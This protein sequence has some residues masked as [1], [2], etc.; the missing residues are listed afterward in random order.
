M[1]TEPYS[2]YTD[3]RPFRIAFLVNPELGAEWIDRII[4]Y[5]RDKWGGRFNPII[6]T[7]GAT[8][9][10][11]WWKFLREYDPDI[12]CSTVPLS[13][14]SRKKIHIF[15]SPLRL[16]ELNPQYNYIRIDDLPVSIFPTRKNISQI[17]F[18]D[19]DKEKE[20]IF[21]E[22]DETTPEVIKTFLNRNFGLFGDERM[23]P[24]HLKKALE[25]C[26]IKKYKV[27]DEIS[28]NEALLD[29]G[30][31][32]TRAV[33]LAQICSL[34]NS[35]KES[36][37]S[38]NNEKFEIIIGDTTDEL[39][40][41]WNRT[42]QMGAWLRTGFTQLWVPRSFAESEVLRP[43]LGK[44]V[45]KYVGTTG[46]DNGRGAHYV[47][48]SLLDSELQALATAI[49][50]GSWHP[51]QATK[52]I[53]H[54]F[55]DYESRG[56]RF[57]LKQ[58][59]DF[60]R[61]HSNEEYLVLNEPSVEEGVMG[62]EHWFTDLYI[63]YRPERFKNIIGRDY[64]W[65]LPRR[66]SILRDLHMFNR[67]A[68]IN[69]RGMFSILMRR[70]TSFSPEDNKVIVKIP[71]DRSVFQTL[72]CGERFDC[73]DREEGDRF[74]SR[75]FYHTQRSDKGM[76][77]SGVLGLFPDL[78]NAQSLFEERYWRET[79]ERMS[80][81]NPEKDKTIQQEL[82]NK[83][84]RK[85]DSGM[86]L[87]NSNKAKEWLAH[88]V[89]NIAKKYSKEEIDLDYVTLK[90]LA[91][92][93][94]DEYNSNPSGQTIPFN[95]SDFKDKLSELIEMGIFL[96][97]VKPKCPRCGYRIWYQVDQVLQKLN[98]RGCGYEFSLPAEP[99][100][101]YRLNSLIRA[102]A[103]L[104]G[105]VPLLI[106][107]GQFMNDAYTSAIFVPSLELLNKVEDKRNEY[108]ICAELDVVCIQDGQF[109]LGEVKQ[110]VGLFHPEDFKR[111]KDIAELVRP[112]KIIFSSL[113]KEPT[114]FVKENIEKLKTELAYLE[115]EVAW[116][117]VRYWIFNP[118]PVR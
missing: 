21:F 1:E 11:S 95:E 9:G 63:Q 44:F 75:P 33:F 14:E 70:K 69:R 26:K 24:Y 22:V 106:T 58:G 59:L 80:N 15:T 37:Y 42:L 40:H 78:R 13:E 94:T 49:G 86:D 89:L 20:L 85:I 36:A 76:Y 102:A 72:L 39:A 104:H 114:E 3:H 68:R 19:F 79:F 64:W 87:K 38:Y 81:H 73:I 12:I 2:I 91:E 35:H 83:L 108:E 65:Q 4:A 31:W 46:N 111:M 103:S 52:L 57:F 47:S 32:Q 101:F 67:P 51:R 62:G 105:T 50:T 84:S 117:P 100:W 90:A 10:D 77:L 110:S 41:F 16:E 5:N 66:N 60:H 25:T 34:P 71:D 54:S 28:L 97:G 74:R 8:I 82:L 48:F 98:C 109:V 23:M 18:P 27:T 61:A 115:I 43:G 17:G 118:G 99:E 30:E 55:P 112:D 93:E 7:D 29:L 107:I 116:Y 88:N 6:F 96:L 53:E 113:D 56:S 45:N 92:K